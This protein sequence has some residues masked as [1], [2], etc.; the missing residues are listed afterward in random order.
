M[1]QISSV[2]QPLSRRWNADVIDVFDTIT[3]FGVAYQS[4]TAF[5]LLL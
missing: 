1:L 3:Y 4:Q 5:I 2:L